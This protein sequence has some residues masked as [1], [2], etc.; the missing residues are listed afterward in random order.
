M[1]HNEQW[2]IT[3]YQFPYETRDIIQHKRRRTRQPFLRGLCDCA[4]PASLVEGVDLYAGE[5]ERGE[6]SAVGIAV[7][8]EAV[9]EDEPSFGGSFGLASAC[10]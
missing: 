1:S 8:A 2:E 10:W 7:V 4:A 9:D 5:S 3:R 6:E